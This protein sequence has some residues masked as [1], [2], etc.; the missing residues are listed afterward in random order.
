MSDN[1]STDE[2]PEMMKRIEGVV[3]S[4]ND[5]NLGFIGSCNRAAAV[6]RG[7]FLVFLNNDTVVTPGWLE[8]FIAPL[9]TSPERDS[10]VPS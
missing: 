2:T 3:Y 6:A 1:A 10:L 7:E 4:R 8:A 5:Q 9:M